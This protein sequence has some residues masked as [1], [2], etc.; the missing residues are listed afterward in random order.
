MERKQTWSW[1]ARW[2]NARNALIEPLNPDTGTRE[3]DCRK[4]CSRV[5]WQGSNVPYAWGGVSQS[6]YLGTAP[7]RIMNI[8]L[9]VIIVRNYSSH[10]SIGTCYSINYELKSDGSSYIFQQKPK[11][12]RPASPLR[13][14][15]LDWHMS[16]SLCTK[17]LFVTFCVNNFL[18]A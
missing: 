14:L 9:R 13:K 4:R 18:T 12:Y 11:L 16:L 2:E 17:L 1:L 7:K 3:K 8:S 6:T 10:K 5:A 15:R